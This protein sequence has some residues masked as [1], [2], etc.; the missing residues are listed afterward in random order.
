MISLVI[1]G[2]SSGKSALAEDHVLTLPGRRIYL[3]TL[4][5]FDDECC[6]R[7]DRHRRMRAHKGFE[8]VEH[9]VDLAGLTLP[10]GANVLLEDLDNLLA[11]ELFSPQGGGVEAVKRGLDS[12]CSRAAHLT[13]VSGDLFAGGSAY[14]GD[15]DGYLRALAACQRRLAARA[16]RVIEAVCGLPRMIKDVT[17]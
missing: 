12:L 7:I 3:A 2:A 15:T 1:G 17:R 14:A 8:T 11:N 16:D 6:A 4:Q 13:V 5:P 10:E 9:S